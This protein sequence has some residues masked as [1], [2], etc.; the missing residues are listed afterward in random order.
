MT[1]LCLKGDLKSVMEYEVTDEYDKII[2]TL[3]K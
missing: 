3:E 1:F 2:F